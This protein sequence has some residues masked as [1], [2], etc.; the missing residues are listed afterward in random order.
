MIKLY[1]KNLTRKFLP[2]TRIVCPSRIVYVDNILKLPIVPV[3][4]VFTQ[5][6]RFESKI[7][8]KIITR[9]QAATDEVDALVKREVTE[10]INKI[11]LE[12]LREVTRKDDP[13]YAVVS[14]KTLKSQP[15][16]LNS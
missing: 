8:L 5:F 9:N 7:R 11:C 1:L 14:G 4:M 2:G 3:V 16:V 13:P 10:K 12:P 15:S 6:D